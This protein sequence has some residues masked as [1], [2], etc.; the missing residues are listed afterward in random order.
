MSKKNEEA[1][2]STLQQIIGTVV[3][4]V[5][6]ALSFYGVQQL[7]KNDL[8]TELKITAEKLNES[9][10]IQVDEYTRLDSTSAIGKTNFIYHYTLFNQ[11]KSEVN[12]DSVDKYFRPILIENIKNSPD[13]KIYRDNNITMAYR[14][15]DKNGVFITEI[16]VS[17]DLYK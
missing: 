2:G 16:S 11:E 10:P 14:Y 9:T 5:A 8:E 17:P 15:F 7:F 1:Q 4:L 12:L 6:F 3:G 13:L